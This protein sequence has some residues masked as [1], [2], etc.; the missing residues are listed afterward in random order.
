MISKKELGYV[1]LWSNRVPY[2][3]R[4]YCEQA[5]DKLE[6]GLL[7][8]EAKYANIKYNI[9]FSNQNEIEFEIKQKNINHMLGI[10]YKNLTSDYFKNFRSDILSCDPEISISSY[11]LLKLIIDNKNKVLDYDENNSSKAINY[12]KISIKADIFSKLADLSK[13]NYGC[14]NFDKNKFLKINPQDKFSSNSTIFLYTESDETVS[15]YFLMGLKKD[16]LVIKTLETDEE[17]IDDVE[18]NNYIVETLI[19][20]EHV[21]KFFDQQQVVIPTQI[22]TDINGKLNKIVAT[23]EEKIKLL[24]E[25]KYIISQYNLP[26]MLDIYG[27]YLSCLMGE[28]RVKVK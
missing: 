22:L 15:P 12:Y 17:E 18:D 3:G 4:E 24:K 9:T 23:S 11:D 21:Y 7:L 13:F 27:D 25:Y 8:Y 5:M 26:N 6:Q 28:Q 10:D 2:P 14:I 20:P 16:E 19:A 1:N